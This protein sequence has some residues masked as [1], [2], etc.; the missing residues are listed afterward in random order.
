M[1]D[2][3]S[4][5]HHPQPANYGRAFA[6][7]IALNAAYVVG[8]LGFG[9]ASRS[10]SLV[11]DAGHNAGDVLGLLMGWCAAVVATRRP[12]ARRTY[13]YR[14][15]TIL[16][17]LA[18]SV[19]LLVTVGAV[20]WEAIVRLSAPVEIP[21]KVVMAV[22]GVG[23]LVNGGTAL[24]FVRGRKGD[25]NIAGAY[26]HM[27]TDTLVALGVVVAGGLMLVTHLAWIDSVVSLSIAVLV[28]IGSY[29]MLRR[30][31]DL[32]LDAVPEGTDANEIRAYLRRLPGVTEVTDLHVWPMSTTEVAL[33]AHVTAPK[34][35][36]ASV[37]ADAQHDMTHRFDIAHST[38]QVDAETPP[39]CPL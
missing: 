16:A 12:N 26:M 38:I 8:E 21:G 24:M 6:I 7:G 4:C 31:L 36:G 37:L 2:H 29:R 27:A 17:A 14:R 22:A 28:G 39:P 11:A 5:D 34:G 3:G 1:H 25:L 15:S 32:A 30:S 13:G 23:I 19:L 33:T 18:N 10:L 35:L 20:A 9:F